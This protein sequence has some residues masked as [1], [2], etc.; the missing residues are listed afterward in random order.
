MD[1]HTPKDAYE[2][3]DKRIIRIALT[4]RECARPVKNLT[5]GDK[6]GIGKMPLWINC[7]ATI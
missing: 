6:I 2:V 5:L 3:A 4:L 1:K 7:N